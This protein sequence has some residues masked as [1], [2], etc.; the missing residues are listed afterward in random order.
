M[1]T[2]TYDVHVQNLDCEH[3]ARALEPAFAQ[4]AGVESLRVL[5][6]AGRITVSFDPDVTSSA[7]L[8]KQLAD[9]GFPAREVTTHAARP[10]PLRNPKVVTSAVSGLLVLCGW[11]LSLNNPESL[12]LAAYVGAMGIGGYYFGREA[13]QVLVFEHEIGIELLMTTAVVTA[14]ILGAPDEGAILVFLYSMPEAAEGYTEEKTRSAVR[15]LM[16]LTPKRTIVRRD[17]REEEVPVEEL[18]VSDV[19]LVRPG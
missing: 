6:K 5:P 3:D 12:S 8:R 15:A 16:D 11:L 14:S 4:V 13:L 1:A 18:I 7:F 17:G 19:F 9:T 10:S 2:E